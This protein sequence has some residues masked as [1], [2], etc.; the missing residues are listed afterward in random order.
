MERPAFN[1]KIQEE[2]KI[3]WKLKPLRNETSLRK[4]RHIL[5]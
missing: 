2:G 1:I 5:K 3:V 4:S